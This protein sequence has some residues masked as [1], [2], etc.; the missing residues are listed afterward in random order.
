MVV[1]LSIYPLHLTR[2]A[3]ELT[4]WWKFRKDVSIKILQK[5]KN[6]LHVDSVII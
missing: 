4:Q 3:C 5:T 2:M 1:E 6:I